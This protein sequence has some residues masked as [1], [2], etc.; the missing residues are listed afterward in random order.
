M[1]TYYFIKSDTLQSFHFLM[2]Y[3]GRCTPLLFATEGNHVSTVELLLNHGALL[4]PPIVI[5]EAATSVMDVP[6]I[7]SELLRTLTPS[8]KCASFYDDIAYTPT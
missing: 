5:Q 7:E 1:R 2:T 3:L 4:D 8:H 6:I